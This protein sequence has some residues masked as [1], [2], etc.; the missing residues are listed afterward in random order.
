[1]H[2]DE[3]DLAVKDLGCGIARECFEWARAFRELVGVSEAPLVVHAPLRLGTDLAQHLNTCERVLS[4]GR[5]FVDHQAV[6]T[7][8]N[9]NGNVL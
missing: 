8:K 9:S 5:L 1:M 6:G 4:R 7:I 3:V 2:D